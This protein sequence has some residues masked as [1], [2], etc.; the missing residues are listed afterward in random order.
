MRKIN[1]SLQLFS[2]NNKAVFE[3]TKKCQPPKVVEANGVA[4]K[5]NAFERI[6]KSSCRQARGEHGVAHAD[7]LNLLLRIAQDALPRIIAS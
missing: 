1:K 6:K 2:K 3:K 5:I 4:P 7:R